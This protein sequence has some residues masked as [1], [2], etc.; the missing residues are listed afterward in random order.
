MA[1]EYKVGDE[2]KVLNDRAVE[3]RMRDPGAEVVLKTVKIH[4]LITDPSGELTGVKFESGTTRYQDGKVEPY[5]LAYPLSR[6]VEE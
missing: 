2:I 3:A 4:E 6:I 5:Y 1:R